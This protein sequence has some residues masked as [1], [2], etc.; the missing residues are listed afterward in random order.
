[1]N[2]ESAGI[3]RLNDF[4]LMQNKRETRARV[5]G[6][7]LPTNAEFF[8]H[9]AAF[10]AGVVVGTAS[11][12]AHLKVGRGHSFSDLKQ[13]S[14]TPNWNVGI[15]TR[16]LGQNSIASNRT[17]PAPAFQGQTATALHVLRASRGRRV[18]AS[19]SAQRGE[20]TA[21]NLTRTMIDEERLHRV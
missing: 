3:R 16:S 8:V 2:A 6:S 11:H 7:N 15:S 20:V 21:S 4:I 13:R 14:E 10:A 9:E 1:M 18:R 19:R 5:D 17:T 12:V